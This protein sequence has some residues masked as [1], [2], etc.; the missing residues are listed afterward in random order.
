M[1][2]DGSAEVDAV[3]ELLD[4]EGRLGVC[5]QNLLGPLHLQTPGDMCEA[6]GTEGLRSRARAGH[7]K[8]RG[9]VAAF[10]PGI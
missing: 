5:A 7:Q 3:H 2:G 4:A 9:L 10:Q 1:P 6:R 8:W